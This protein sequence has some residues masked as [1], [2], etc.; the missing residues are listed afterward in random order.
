V[1]HYH[2]ERNL[3]EAGSFSREVAGDLQRIVS[4]ARVT[5]AE[6]R[7]SL[8]TCRRR[9]RR[10]TAT[11]TRENCLGQSCPRFRDCF[12]MAA[13]REALAADLVVVNHICSSPM[14]M[15]KDEGM[16]EL[17]P[18]CNTVIFDEAHQLPE[19]ATL[20]FG[21]SLSTGQII[22]L[23]RDVRA[24]CSPQRRTCP[25]RCGSLPRWTRRP[26]I[27]ASLFPTKAPL[28]R[29]IGQAKARSLGCARPRR[30]RATLGVRGPRGALRTQR[31]SCAL[32]GARPNRAGTARALARRQPRRSG[33]LD[34][35]IQS[36]ASAECD[37]ALRRSIFRRQ[38]D[39]HRAPGF[40]RPRRSR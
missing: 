39:G 21:E 18:A 1:C 35:G 36:F 13:R 4:F 9:L 29:G 38:L 31:R 20:F 2:L 10:G 6:T 25:I 27:C 28:H 22:E 40:L 26:G 33:P 16:A 8:P 11:S 15:L 3:A 24:K 37:A 34:R 19:T 30:I 5:R 17:L 12:V 14:L 23:T 7:A 32:R